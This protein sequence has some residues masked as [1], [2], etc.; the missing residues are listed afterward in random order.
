MSSQLETSQVA[1]PLAGKKRGTRKYRSDTLWL[2]A[3]VHRLSG[4]LLALFLPFHFLALGLAIEGAGPL[5]RF[6]VWTELPLV[7]LA[8]AGLVALLTVHLLGGIRILL[9]ETLPWQPNQKSMATI[10]IGV[11]LVAG[12]FFLLRII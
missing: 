10:A 9:I 6:L 1:G 7:K 3:L 12:A 8:E 4:V 2:A 5:D 11:A